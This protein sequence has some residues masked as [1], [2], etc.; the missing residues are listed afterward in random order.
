M[1]RVLVVWSFTSH[2]V[3]VD[4]LV[5]CI[6]DVGQGGNLEIQ[7]NTVDMLVVGVGKRATFGISIHAIVYRCHQGLPLRLLRR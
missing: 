5:I 3:L 6:R 1:P 7:T 4:S 2:D